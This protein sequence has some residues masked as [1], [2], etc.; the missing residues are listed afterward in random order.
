MDGP[1]NLAAYRV[2]PKPSRLT[3]Q[4]TAAG[5]LSAFG[6][7]PVI[8]VRDFTGEAKFSPDPLERASVH[9]EVK[10]ASLEVSGDVSEKDR[11]FPG[12]HV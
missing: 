7:N 12:H 6:H 2:E 5:L 10:A 4:V 11:G 9:V 3:V 8:A 1:N